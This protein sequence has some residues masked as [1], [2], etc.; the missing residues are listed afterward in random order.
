[1]IHTITGPDHY[2]PFIALSKSGKWS[3]K[4]TLFWTFACGLAHVASS[5]L[6]G[7]I[8]IWIGWSLSDSAF[9]EGVRGSFS[10]WLLFGFGVLYFL[11][12]LYNLQQNKLHKHF[13]V[14]EA[15]NIYVYEHREGQAVLPNQKFMVT[16][17]VLF[18]IFAMGPSEPI[19][20]LLF[21]SALEQTTFQLFLLIITYT[22]STI[23]VIEIVVLLGYYGTNYIQ[24]PN[25]EKYI[26]LLSGL[27]ILMC[28]AG[29]LFLGW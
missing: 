3:L 24:L 12:S 29:M 14:D 6:I 13:E 4:K 1:M 15:A 5:I 16:P 25:F 23:L 2:L 11:W 19:I 8:A 21:Y 28:G 27:V 9:I 22:L 17:W 26:G 18:F 10:A 20:P 7:C